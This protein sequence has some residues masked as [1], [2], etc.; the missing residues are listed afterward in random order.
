MVLNITQVQK[1]L[2]SFDTLPVFKITNYP[3]VDNAYRPFTLGR[4]CIDENKTLTMRVLCF[5]QN[6]VENED[7]LQSEGIVFCFLLKGTLYALAVSPLGK[8]QLYKVTGNSLKPLDKTIPIS[9]TP[10]AGGDQQGDYWGVDIT[11]PIPAVFEG[12]DIQLFA[13]GNSFKGNFYKLFF[14]NSVL[15][16]GSFFPPR[17]FTDTLAILCS[18]ENLGDI[19]ITF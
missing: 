5:E 14:N 8:S 3:N 7:I 16:A 13:P 10:F 17:E 6:P 19:K 15:K 11:I 18:S 12:K 9:V 2:F 1:D 4:F